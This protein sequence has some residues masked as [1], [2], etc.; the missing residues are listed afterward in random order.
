MV[1]R[2]VAFVVV[3]IKVPVI[4]MTFPVLRRLPGTLPLARLAV[5]A[6][7]IVVPLP[8]KRILAPQP[9]QVPPIDTAP[10]TWRSPAISAFLCVVVETPTPKA[11]TMACEVDA[12]ADTCKLVEV[13]AV[14]VAEVMVN[15]VKV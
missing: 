11:P 12:V 13:A 9:L 4:S 1:N 10:E 8:V 5:V 3:A 15:C 7:L 6:P 14:A 2:V